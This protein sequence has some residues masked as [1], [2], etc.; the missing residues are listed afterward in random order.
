MLTVPSLK[1]VN[2][3]TKQTIKLI[4]LDQTKLIVQNTPHQSTKIKTN[5][6]I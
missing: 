5:H 4:W 3:Y 1:I 6:S 2:H